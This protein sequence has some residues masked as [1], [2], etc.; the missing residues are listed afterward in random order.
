MLWITA[1][2]LLGL[3]IVFVTYMSWKRK[4]I[5]EAFQ[6]LKLSGLTFII[7]PEFASYRGA[8]AQYGRVK[9]DGVIGLSPDKLIFIPFI[10]PKKEILTNNICRVDEQKT[11]LGQFRAG[12]HV[13][14]IHEDKA[15]IGF[16]V[17]DIATW[18]NAIEA[19]IPKEDR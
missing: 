7:G 16:F 2:M 15:D 5:I 18:Q 6:A 4:K 1:L 19:L 13:L 3:I 10:G 11:F 12:V 17:K 14:V 9:C 8:T